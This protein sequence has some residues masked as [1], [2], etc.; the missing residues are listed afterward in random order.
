MKK[1]PG[2]EAPGAESALGPPGLKRARERDDGAAPDL[3]QERQEFF[4]PYSKP[5]YKRVFTDNMVSKEF[6]VFVESTKEEQIGNKNPDMMCS[7]FKNELKG[8]VGIRRINARKLGVTFGQI[9]HA[10]NFLHDESFLTKYE[11]KAYIPARSVETIGVLRFVP[12]NISNEDLFKK[13]TSTHEII[14]VRRFT[15]KVNG[16]ITPYG[17]VSVTFLSQLLPEVAYLDLYRFKVHEYNA[18]L[19]QCYKCF[20]FNHGAKFCKNSQKCSRCAGDHHFTTCEREEDSIKC[21]NCQGPHLAISKDCPVKQK[22][23]AEKNKGSSSYSQIVSTN[24]INYDKK[25]PALPPKPTLAVGNNVKTATLQYPTSSKPLIKENCKPETSVGNNL[26]EQIL[27]SEY[28]LKALVGALVTIG[29]DRRPITS[30]IVKEI[31]VKSFTH[32]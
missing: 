15:R 9:I 26:I 22:K 11:L 23:I 20:K 1:P 27:N 29:N 4:K 19:L 7:L 14:S 28:I 24:N 2:A 12:T 31:L 13:L 25:Y 5:G 10:N 8:V 6:T 18:P 21:I 32:G 16:V 17:S 30:N 3:Q